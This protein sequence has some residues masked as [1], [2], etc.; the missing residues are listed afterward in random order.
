M[1]KITPFLWFETEAQEAANYYKSVFNKESEPAKGTTLD[2]T[3]SGSVQ[4]ININILG[5]E[6]TLMSAGPFKKFNE[7]ISFV[8]SC[9]NQEEVDYY[10]EK[11]SSD[12]SAEQC[13]WCKDKFGVSWQIVPKRLNELMSDSDK[14]KANR[15]TQAMLKM[16][17]IVIS[18]LEDASNQK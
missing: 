9:D 11:L 17:K 1:Q 10:W 15:V 8:V 2:N 13:G 14:E 16:K 7:A 12:K 6:M 3:P 5:Q 4:I 18:E